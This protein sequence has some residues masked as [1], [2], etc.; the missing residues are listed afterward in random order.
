MVLQASAGLAPEP[1][2]FPRG[3]T[4]KAAA[5]TGTIA[6]QANRIQTP[7]FSMV[8]WN[9]EFTL[10][11]SVRLDGLITFLTVEVDAQASNNKSNLA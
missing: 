8:R 5:W 10:L 3:E 7:G 4:K 1:P 6:I 11:P 2:S 9:R